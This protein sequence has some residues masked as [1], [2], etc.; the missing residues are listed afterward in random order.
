MAAIRP[1][2]GQLW[3]ALTPAYTLY[4]ESNTDQYTR[5][6]LREPLITHNTGT[7]PLLHAYS[8][9]HP[10]PHTP[11]HTQADFNSL[12]LNYIYTSTPTSAHPQTDLD[13]CHNSSCRA[14]SSTVSRQPQNSRAS[15]HGISNSRGVFEDAVYTLCAPSQVPVGQ[16]D[17][18]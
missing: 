6:L 14:G 2:R 13:G 8:L 5:Y 11:K 18:W 10:H 16:I 9:P 15:R 3:A 7:R 1:H 4:V 12:P 17:P